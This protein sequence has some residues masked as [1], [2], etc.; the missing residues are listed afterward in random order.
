M[1]LASV[2]GNIV[3][4]VVIAVI[5]AINWAARSK[6]NP[7]YQPPTV[8]PI[9]PPAGKE[10]EEARMRR[11][12][13]ALGVPPDQQPPPP[14][15]HREPPALPTP[16]PR[17]EPRGSIVSSPWPG[18]EKKQRQAAAGVPKRVPPPL[19]ERPP[20]TVAEKA[21]AADSAP[22]LWETVSSHVSA[23]P[24][25]AS[26]ADMRDAYKSAELEAEGPDVR[27][28]LRSPS[29]LRAAILLREIIGPPRGLQIEE[30]FPTFR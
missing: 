6:K 30:R 7:P 13:E 9:R 14:V 16:L 11:F 18:R 29:D 19:V 20:L 1:M 4:L 21:G 12:L 24:F 5:A 28:L 2:E 23:I 17:I 27:T 8:E 22:P 15:K 26:H 25:E 3:T 10:S